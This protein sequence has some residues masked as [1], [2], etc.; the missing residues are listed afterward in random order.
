MK[1]SKWNF[2]IILGKKFGQDFEVKNR[3]Y[4]HL[5]RNGFIDKLV[6]TYLFIY[7]YSFTTDGNN[8][9]I[10][11]NTNLYYI[12]NFY[13]IIP[14]LKQKWGTRT[15]KAKNRKLNSNPAA[16]HPHWSR[17]RRLSVV[18]SL[19]EPRCQLYVKQV[20]MYGIFRFISV[21]NPPMNSW[22]MS[23]PWSAVFTSCIYI[24]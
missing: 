18:K 3:L 14:K 6:S 5:Y 24:S 11:I 1:A 13:I 19:P 15:T 22:F 10:L 4:F 12:S 17:Q 9:I 16:Y 2:R 7:I 20:R 8:L 21:W 23:N